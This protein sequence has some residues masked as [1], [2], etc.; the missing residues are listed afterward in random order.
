VIFPL[1]LLSNSRLQ[2]HATALDLEVVF[3]HEYEMLKSKLCSVGQTDDLFGFLG[4]ELVF[5]KISYF[6][7]FSK[8]ELTLAALKLH[9]LCSLVLGDD[10]GTWEDGLHLLS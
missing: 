3:N 4:V 7:G 8:D 9:P 1:S 5:P 6:S 2:T 10:S